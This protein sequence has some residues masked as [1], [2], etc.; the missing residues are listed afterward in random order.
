MSR[1]F[2]LSLVMV[3]ALVSGCTHMSP[4]HRM[5]TIFQNRG[6]AHYREI[7]FEIPVVDPVEDTPLTSEWWMGLVQ[8]HPWTQFVIGAAWFAAVVWIFWSVRRQ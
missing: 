7:S 3:S 6:P 8:T 5:G 2:C 4:D 1:V